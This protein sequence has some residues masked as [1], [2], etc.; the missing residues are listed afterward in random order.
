MCCIKLCKEIC[1]FSFTSCVNKG[2]IIDVSRVEKVVIVN[3]RVDM[4][5]FK[6]SHV[7]G[8]I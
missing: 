5:F 7:D 6:V 2:N 4:F 3:F 1:E 8:D